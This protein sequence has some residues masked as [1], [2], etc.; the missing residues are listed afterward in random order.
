MSRPVSVTDTISNHLVSYDSGYSAYSVSN[1]QNA[2]ADSD[3]TSYAQINLTR[4]AN[5]V[6]EIYYNF[7]TL[8]IPSGAT[9]NSVTCTCK[10]SIN[11][12]NSSRVTTRQARLYTGTTAMGSAYTV[13]NS[14]TAF[15]IT[16]G[17]W[18]VAQLNSGVKLR[19]YAVRGTS[20]TTSSYYFRLYG[21]TLSVSYSISGTEYE[22]SIINNS[23]IATPDPSTTQYI[24]QGGNQDIIFNGVTDPNTIVVKDNNVEV[25]LTQI[26]EKKT[27]GF[28]PSSLVSSSGTVTDSSN[29]LTNSSS[30]T[31]AQAGGQSGQ[32]LIYSFDVSSIPSNA[33]IV[34]VECT[35]KAQHTH[36]STTYGS[37]Q[38]Y[39]GSTAKG[40]ASTFRATTTMDLN[41]GSWT[42]S[43]LSDIRIR[44]GN[45]YTGGTT[46]Y[47]T[48][49]YGADLTVVYTV[50]GD[51]CYGYT[52]SNISADHTIVISDAVSAKVYLKVNGS[53]VQ[54]TKVYKKISGSW[55]EQTD[56]SNLFDSNTIYI[57][58]N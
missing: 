30:D 34:S 11:T 57:K 7:D 42:R 14:T 28:I 45:T 50:P 54:A 29:G 48:R 20:N 23:T 33:T 2:Y 1:L 41:C 16:T 27:S 8:N 47:Y 17:T 52:I 56:F 24:F 5:A 55:V 36:S 19:L 58:E 22:V 3:N 38:L 40:T 51:Y 35:A 44:I 26:L 15:S 49:F 32:Y 4:N 13:A 12:T 53:W 9:I 25:S 46:T 39:S 31:Y 37:I 21:A 18:T 10:C 6:T 43:E